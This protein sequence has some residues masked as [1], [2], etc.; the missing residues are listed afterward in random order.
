VIEWQEG[1]SIPLH[2]KESLIWEAG[3]ERLGEGENLHFIPPHA[4]EY[5]I[6]V[7]QKDGSVVATLHLHVVD[8]E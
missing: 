3:K 4:G 5:T 1:M 2:A 8:K 6:I 7:R